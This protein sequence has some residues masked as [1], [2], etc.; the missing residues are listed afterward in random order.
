MYYSIHGTLYNYIY[1]VSPV[2]LYTAL[3]LLNP[4]AAMEHFLRTTHFPQHLTHSLK[5]L[6][7]HSILNVLLTASTVISGA[8]VAGND[9]GRAY[10]TFPLMVCVYMCVYCVCIL[11]V[12]ISDLVIV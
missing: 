9:A 10:G 5:T 8:Y 11:Y 7:R 4:K 12:C 2:R 1:T 6:H 3:D